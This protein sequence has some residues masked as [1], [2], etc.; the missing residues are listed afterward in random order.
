M[1]VRTRLVEGSKA[2][3]TPP[4]RPRPRMERVAANRRRKQ[5]GQQADTVISWAPGTRP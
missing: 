1:T 4:K 5:A 3:I 2:R